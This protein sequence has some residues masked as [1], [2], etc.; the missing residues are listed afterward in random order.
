MTNHCISIP[1][2]MDY[3]MERLVDAFFWRDGLHSWVYESRSI[4]LHIEL[5]GHIT[6]GDWQ[7][8]PAGWKSLPDHQLKVMPWLQIIRNT[9]Y[10]ANVQ[11]ILKHASLERAKM[12]AVAVY[13]FWTRRWK[14]FTT[15][16]IVLKACLL[17]YSLKKPVF[18]ISI[19]IV[20]VS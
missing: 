8:V 4:C 18:A 14:R 17:V 19:S 20:F 13:S 3:C 1:F 2:E 10:T 6:R 9:I 11:W 16:G 5:L 7:M 12:T 15:S